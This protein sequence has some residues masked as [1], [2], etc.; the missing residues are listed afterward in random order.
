MSRPSRFSPRSE[1]HAA[2]EE[3]TVR[4]EEL[5]TS[6]VR[7]L[8][9][10]VETKQARFELV[11][12][13]RGSGKSHL[14]GLVEG[15][16]LELLEGKAIVAGLPEEFHPSSL[17]H[18]LAEILRS[19]PRRPEDGPIERQLAILAASPEDARDRAVTMIR[20]SLRGRPL[21][22]V[23]ENLDMVFVAIGRQGQ[24]QLRSILQTERSWS[25]VASSRSQSP[26]FS[27]ESEPFYGTFIPRTLEPLSAEDCR[28]MLVRL[29]RA[30]DREELVAELRS[31][32]GLARV[33]TLRHVLGGYPRAMAFIFP[34]LHHDRPLAVE[35]ALDALAEE[36][37]P[38]FQEQVGRLAPGQRPVVELLAEHWSPLSVSEISSA[39]FSPQATTS[40]FLRRLRQD[41]IVRCTKLGREHFYEISDPL[42]RIAR[43]MQRE[44]IRAKT[45]LRVLR[46]WYEFRGLDPSWC[47]CALG[48]WPVG[49][50]HQPELGEYHSKLFVSLLAKIMS[51]QPH[52]AL[53][54]LDAID[55]HHPMRNAVRA[56]AYGCLGDHDR[57]FVE[58]LSVESTEFAATVG[59]VAALGR[60]PPFMGGD[61]ELPDEHPEPLVLELCNMLYAIHE[62]FDGRAWSSLQAVEALEKVLGRVPADARRSAADVV[63]RTEVLPRLAS[64]HQ[65]ACCWRILSCLEPGHGEPWSVALL[66]SMRQAWALGCLGE[67]FPSPS[68]ALG[69]TESSSPLCR[70]GCVLAA[71][72]EGTT[73]S[74]VLDEVEASLARVQSIA[75]HRLGTMDAMWLMLISMILL[76]RPHEPALRGRFLAWFHALPEESRATVSGAARAG[77]LHW[78]ALGRSLEP[79]HAPGARE[80]LD[81]LDLGDPWIS[82]PAEANSAYVRMSAFERALIR[83]IARSLGL[84]ERHRALCELSDVGS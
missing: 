21:V 47:A 63:F 19:L 80:M 64:A 6:I 18:L 13:P 70:V 81:G 66:M 28:E 52:Q 22:I 15:R 45:F 32:S 51:G 17:V 31:P 71:S 59:F 43:A 4:R 26:A 27:K 78:V 73:S 56:V 57:S 16:L 54:E 8:T 60:D 48:K 46:G 83:D 20:A 69:A 23:I 74:G 68:A 35:Q 30:C 25:I 39:T 24:H 79:L 53:E 50:P 62:A 5:C 67:V 10:A 72:D 1:P 36:L 11:L 14:L 2:L 75:L 3:R 9:D 58:L 82:M 41:S 34:H 38:Y 29:G 55:D 65:L 49:A 44:E 12:G 37:T 61:A 42:F 33:R 77:I 7:G 84:H 40:T 76:E